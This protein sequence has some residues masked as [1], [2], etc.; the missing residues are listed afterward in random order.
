MYRCCRCFACVLL[1]LVLFKKWFLEEF[2]R[3]SL[4]PLFTFVSFFSPVTG[5][6]RLLSVYIRQNLKQTRHPDT[7]S[8]IYSS[9]GRDLWR[10]STDPWGSFFPLLKE[11]KFIVPS[12]I[13]YKITRQFLSWGP[14][15]TFYF[16]NPIKQSQFSFMSGKKSI[17]KH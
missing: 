13:H 9:S 16:S 17:L 15:E 1:I 3:S 11:G 8:L 12:F 5:Y 10:F 4:S 14:R 2:P 6:F 7:P